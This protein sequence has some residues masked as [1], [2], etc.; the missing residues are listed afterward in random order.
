MY[1]AEPPPFEPQH[2]REETPSSVASAAA[3]RPP[4]GQFVKE[5]KGGKLRLRL[6]RQ[7]DN[8]TV[9]VFGIRGPVEGTLQLL[10]PKGLAFVAVRVSI[11]FICALSSG[12]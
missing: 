3:A 4:G 11:S 8:A 5:S 2:L 9:P 12:S 6:Y 1:S 7:T 10:N